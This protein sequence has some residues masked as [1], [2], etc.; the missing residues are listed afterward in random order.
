[1]NLN[2]IVVRNPNVISKKVNG[3]FIILDPN[4]GNLYNLNETAYHIWKLTRRPVKISEVIEQVKAKFSVDSKAAQKQIED[5]INKY[6][7][8]LF[9]KV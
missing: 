7:N 6:S 3:E 9:Y 5:F 2:T 4:H 1:M 8:T